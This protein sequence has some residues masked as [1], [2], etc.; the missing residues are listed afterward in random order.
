MG[1]NRENLRFRFWMRDCEHGSVPRTFTT[2]FKLLRVKLGLCRGDY[3]IFVKDVADIRPAVNKMHYHEGSFISIFYASN[4]PIFSFQDPI[5]GLFASTLPGCT[6]H[7]WV[8]DNV[9]AVH[10]IWGLSLAYKKHTDFDEDR[11]K[12]YELEQVSFISFFSLPSRFIQ[13]SFQ[14]CI[15]VM[16]SLLVCM[17]RQSDKVELFKQSQAPKDAL[18]AKY[19][20]R[21]RGAVVGDY[22][23][24][25]LQIDA[26]SLYLLTLAQMTA[27]GKD[28]FNYSA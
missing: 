26:T 11:A 10:C 7:A 1:K 24:G 12:A 14:M 23:W 15:K 27:C 22:D 28:N 16:R 25:H 21:N 8:R 9:Y 4:L 5:T 18:H 2:A 20:A 13:F 3:G 6:D 19:S 17:M